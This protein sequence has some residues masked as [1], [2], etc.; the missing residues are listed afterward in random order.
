MELILAVYGQLRPGRLGW[1]RLDL[2][3]RV[4]VVGECRI[5]GRIVDCGG[6]PGLLAGDG[7]VVGD[8]I[9]VSDAAVLADLDRYEAY[10]PNDL[11]ASEYQRRAA[12]LVGDERRVESYFYLGDTEGMPPIEGGDWIA[13]CGE[14]E[15]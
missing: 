9:R 12:Q 8:L 1:R 13:Y 3:A 10:N 15:R 11:A 14:E 7:E 2:G 4:E 5:V 6:Y